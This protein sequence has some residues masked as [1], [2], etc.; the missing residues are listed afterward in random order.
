MDNEI[1]RARLFSE[2]G[3]ELVMLRYIERISISFQYRYIESYRIG[4]LDVNIFDTSSHPILFFGVDFILILTV[5]QVTKSLYS[6]ELTTGVKF[7][8][9]STAEG[10]LT[11]RTLTFS[12][13][14]VSYPRSF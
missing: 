9:L 13:L 1:E 7:N 12:Y 11:L 5:M 8:R 2:A 3:S 14:G 6:Y 10:F 4:R